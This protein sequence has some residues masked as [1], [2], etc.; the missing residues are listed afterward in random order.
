[1]RT[2][3]AAAIFTFLLSS[4]CSPLAAQTNPVPFL[5]NPTVPAAAVPGG[6]GFTLAVNG[7]GFVSGATILWNGSPR[8]TTFVN[9][10]QLSAAIFAADVATER[11]VSITVSNPR[12]G[13]GVSNAVL[14]SVTTPTKSLAFTQAVLEDNFQGWIS[15]PTGLLAQPNPADGVPVVAVSNAKCV[16]PA[17]CTL[18]TGTIAIDSIDQPQGFLSHDIQDSP[19]TILGGDFNGDGVLDYVTLGAD[20][21][22]NTPFSGWVS[23]GISGG[24]LNSQ[25]TF[26]LPS[27]STASP[28]PIAG[29]F[30]GDGRLDI[31][32]GGQSAVFFVPGNGDGTFGTPISSATESATE[33]GLAAGDFN[34]DGILDLAVTNSLLN[35]VS[36]L[37]GNGDGTFKAPADFATGSSPGMVATGDFNGDGKLDLAILDSSGT[38]ISILLGNGDGTFKTNVE[39][40]AALA[41]FALAIGD[42]NGDGI[43]DIAVSDTVGLVNILLGNGDG[44]FQSP[45]NFTTGGEPELIAATT[46]GFDSLQPVGRA[47]FAVVDPL[48]NAVL[49]FAPVASQTGPGNPVPT[50]STISPTSAV[51]GS[52]SFTLAVNG[53][54]FLMSSTISF[55]GQAEP[56][57]FVSASQLTAAIPASAIATPGAELVLVSTPAPD[58]GV[59]ESSFAV[60]LPPPTISAIIPSIAVAGSPGFTLTINGA[61]FVN[62][63]TVNFNSSSRSAVFVNSTQITASVLPADVVNAGTINISVTDPIGVGNS[64]G[65]TTSSTTLTVLP[66]NS[67][68]TVGALSPASAFAGGQGFTLTIGGT[69]FLPTSVVTFGSK[70]VNSAYQS[71]NELQ[72]SVPAS[73]IAVAGTPLV[74]VANSGGN[75]SVAVSFAVNNPVPAAAS[76]SPP[77]VPAGNAAI[78]INV[79]GT[80]F[81][82]GS[83]VQVNGSSRATTF[84]SP[85]SLT[86]ALLASDFSSSGTLNITVNNPNPGGGTTSPLELPVVAAFNVSA[87]PQ[88]ATVSAGL[89]AGYSLMLAPANGQPTLNGAVAFSISPLSPLPAGANA[90]FTPSNVP[91]GSAG[92][93]VMLAITTTPRASGSF[94]QVPL[95]EW[96]HGTLLLG[97]GLAIGMMWFALGAL[98]GSAGRLAPRFLILVS[99]VVAAGL[100]A[101][102]ISGGSPGPQV[103]TVTGT[104]AGIYMIT[105]NAT[106]G[107][108]TVPTTVTLTVK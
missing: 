41:G 13:G 101:C 68:P 1:M 56:T 7:A 53:S 94:V 17:S 108:A 81:V 75:P 51:E 28:A 91:A 107:N 8:V 103:N 88:S 2:I 26:S 64:G 62:G 18:D 83:T 36:I 49:I 45:L 78:T 33:G 43:L 74:T 61:N 21:T 3:I 106:S 67:Q 99:F 27:G 77:S 44:T 30:D 42:F 6:A 20:L 11:I 19:Q 86:A 79:T 70:T 14:F 80:N 98:R 25:Q 95:G 93:N 71:P 104:P 66:A 16:V 12:P 90:T 39:Y 89:P 59:A 9:G 52:G 37:N 102:G 55:G 40:P 97:A 82:P 35:T 72:A 85:T 96:P 69:G 57:T 24:G 50:I 34:G 87:T 73:A 105:V 22:T 31:I 84:V 4:F 76:I 5:N 38:N 58:G 32:T 60:V 54:N 47:G 29:D 15:E 63:S 100:T 10:T 48:N 65:G 92:T 23:L 46:F